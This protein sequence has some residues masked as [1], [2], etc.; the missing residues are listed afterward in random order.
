MST[1]NLDQAHSTIGF[2]VKR[3]MVST[4][5]GMFT[6]FTGTI[7]SADDSFEKRTGS[8]YRTNSKYQYCKYYAR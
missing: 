3:L 6:D 2:K 7:E 8:F 1:W 4:V 5:R